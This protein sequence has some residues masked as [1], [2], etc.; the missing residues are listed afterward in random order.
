[1]AGTKKAANKATKKASANA[2][3]PWVSSK[4]KKLL[5]KDTIEGRVTIEMDPLYVYG[6]RDE[7]MEYELKN[8]NTN[9][10]N[11]HSVIKREQDCAHQDG[12]AHA[13]D[14]LLHHPILQGPSGYP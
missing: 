5:R 9:F 2:R 14:I 12:H 8:F 1:M 10:S 7:Y 4:A 6:M 3:T 13:H 11:L